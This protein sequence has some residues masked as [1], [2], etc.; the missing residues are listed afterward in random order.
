MGQNFLG[1]LILGFGVVFLVSGFLYIVLVIWAG[2]VGCA[3]GETV[4]RVIG[5]SG[6]CL[7]F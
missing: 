2:G 3:S 1:G 4:S 7:G 5:C 6:G